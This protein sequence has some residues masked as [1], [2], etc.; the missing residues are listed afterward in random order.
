MTALLAQEAVEHTDSMG[1]A[2]SQLVF[3]GV[4]D[5]HGTSVGKLTVRGANVMTGH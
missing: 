4:T 2:F 5:G 1:Y 3:G